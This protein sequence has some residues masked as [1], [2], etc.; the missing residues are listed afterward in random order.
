MPP[1]RRVT[2]VTSGHLSTCPRMLK[3]ADALAGAGY[4]VR[5]VATAHEPWATVTDLDVRLRRG[6]PM[7]VVNY[8]KGAERTH[9]LVD[10]YRASRGACRGIGGRPRPRADAGRGPRL[11]ARPRRAGP[12]G[13]RA[14]GRSDL[15]RHDRRPGR[16]CRSGAPH[17]DAVRG[18][19][20]G[21]AQR[22]DQ[23]SGCAGDRRARDAHRAG[24][25]R[26]R[27][28]RHDVERSDCRRISAPLRRRRGGGAQHLSAAVRPPD[29]A[30]V[31]IRTP[32]A[33]T[34]SARR[35]GPAAG[36]KKR[37]PRSGGS[38]SPRN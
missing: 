37:S 20:R 7:S 14:A 22:R 9:V 32:F 6:W 17:A 10:R 19:L 35:S 13:L 8:R 33:P 29:F 2:V 18:G 24:R 16:D 21:S 12:C 3:S 28:V 34:G 36:S 38:A 25:D 31:A 4:D 27:G 23:R 5:V 1:R 11:R 26:R 15:R 30:R